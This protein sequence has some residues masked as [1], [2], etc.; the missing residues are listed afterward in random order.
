MRNSFE[1]PVIE[2]LRATTLVFIYGAKNDAERGY[3]CT[4]RLGGSRSLGI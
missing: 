4:E 2:L 1:K 3:L